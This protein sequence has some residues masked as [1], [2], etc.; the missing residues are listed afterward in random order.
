MENN[1]KMGKEKGRIGESQDDYKSLNLSLP[2]I[3]TVSKATRIKESISD[4]CKR[5]K[6][7]IVTLLHNQKPIVQ[8]HIYILRQKFIEFARCNKT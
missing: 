1:K 5:T 4:I 7:N 6:A 3:F 2:N 8:F